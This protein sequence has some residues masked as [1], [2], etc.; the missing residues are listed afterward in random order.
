MVGVSVAAVVIVSDQQGRILLGED[1]RECG[2]GLLHGSGAERAGGPLT[3]LRRCVTG[4]GVVEE[5]DP[6][7][8][9]SV[10]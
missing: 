3:V 10:G 7:D 1:L 2:S 4:I 9:E 5:R 8:A 6:S